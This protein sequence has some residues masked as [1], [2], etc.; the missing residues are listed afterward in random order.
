[1]LCEWWCVGTNDSR[2]RKMGDR[3]NAREEEE[4]AKGGHRNIERT[5]VGVGIKKLGLAPDDLPVKKHE[6]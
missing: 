4:R 3:E 1:M 2:F 5:D 6:T